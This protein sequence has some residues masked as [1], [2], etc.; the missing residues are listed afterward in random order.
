MKHKV[1]IATLDKKQ[2]Q[3]LVAKF[4]QEYFE[5]IANITKFHINFIEKNELS[6]PEIEYIKLLRFITTAIN[7][8]KALDPE[9]M[10]DFMLKVYNDMKTLHELYIDFQKRTKVGKIVYRRDFLEGI[11]PYRDLVENINR[12]EGLKNSY[13]SIIQ[14]TENELSAMKK[15]KGD[16]QIA[17]YKQLKRRNVDAIS[18][19][20]DAKQEL[21][22]L[23]R[24]LIQ[25]ENDAADE[26]FSQ[27]ENTR[28]YYIKSLEKILSI[29]ILYLDKVLWFKAQNSSPIQA[30][31]ER[32]MIKGD[33]STKTFIQY[34][35][36]NVNIGQSKQD[37]WHAYLKSCLEE[38]EKDGK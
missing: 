35:L 4:I 32:A 11:K 1:E 27:F 12:L 22:R 33:Y 19:Y 7:N 21:V 26:F 17:K 14:S 18:N 9:I 30:F 8:L 24:A 37:G 28:D 13:Y 6:E 20:A 5:D 15:P 16:A 25:L 29:K 10:D 2:I 38:W 31:F 36:K 3:E 23:N 34:Y